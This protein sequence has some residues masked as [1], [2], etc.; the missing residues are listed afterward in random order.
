MDEIKIGFSV[1]WA[2]IKKVTYYCCWLKGFFKSIE[3]NRYRVSLND[4]F[5][6]ITDITKIEKRRPPFGKIQVVAFQQ[7]LVPI[8]RRRTIYSLSQF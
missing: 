7:I 6:Q 3:F 1:V 5:S 2:F 8:S 4:V